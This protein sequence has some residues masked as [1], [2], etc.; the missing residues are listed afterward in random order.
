MIIKVNNS[1]YDELELKRNSFTLIIQC[2]KKFNSSWDIYEFKTKSSKVYVSGSNVMKMIIP[3]YETLCET[4]SIEEMIEEAIEDNTSIVKYVFVGY[5]RKQSL[6]WVFVDE[7]FHPVLLW[8]VNEPVTREESEKERIRWNSIQWWIHLC[9]N[10]KRSPKEHSRK[11]MNKM[12]DKYFKKGEEE[13]IEQRWTLGNKW[14]NL[15]SMNDSY[16]SLSP[17]REDELIVTICMD[18]NSTRKGM[19]CIHSRI[20]VH[21]MWMWVWTS[22]R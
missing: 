9:F 15:K 7:H 4:S 20:T 12:I 8:I 6:Y 3:D 13:A 18:I 10:E 19:C 14:R 17:M 16:M 22:T 5:W 2:F 21:R 1:E 11:L